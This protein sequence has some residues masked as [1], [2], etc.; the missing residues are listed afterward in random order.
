LSEREGGSHALTNVL[1]VD[2]HQSFAEA[3]ELVLRST[4]ASA[5]GNSD[6]SSKFVRAASVAEGLRLVSE[7]GPFDL[8]VVDLMLPDGNGTTVVREIK[9]R[10]PGTLVAVVSASE[11]L[12][13]ALAAGADEAIPKETSFAEIVA[14]LARL[15]GVP[16]QTNPKNA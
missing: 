1:I 8:A 15:A 11:D 3:L 4:F 9:A 14:S 6:V 2:D 5:P 10:T 16:H 13:E 7:E 12:S